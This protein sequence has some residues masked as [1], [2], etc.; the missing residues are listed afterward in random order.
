[1]GAVARFRL[2]TCE[3]QGA[4]DAVRVGIGLQDKGDVLCG[5][6]HVPHRL[7]ALQRPQPRDLGLQ[8]V[9]HHVRP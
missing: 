7:H 6:K 2:S 9:A 4:G 3:G 8:A 5:A 1:M